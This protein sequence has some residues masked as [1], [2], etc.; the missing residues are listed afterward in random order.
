MLELAEKRWRTSTDC[1]SAVNEPVD[2]NV[3]GCRHSG[4]ARR[5][6][7]L[8]GNVRGHRLTSSRASGRNTIAAFAL[9]IALGGARCGGIRRRN[10]NGNHNSHLKN[11]VTNARSSLCHIAMKTRIKNAKRCNTDFTI[12]SKPGPY[13]RFRMRIPFFVMSVLSYTSCRWR[14]PEITRRWAFDKVHDS[15]GATGTK[16]TLM[17]P[18]LRQARAAVLPDLS[19]CDAH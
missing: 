18:G 13:L 3:C 5:T 11:G 4:A 1:Y 19:A 15:A 12:R 9:S 6:G 7:M 16:Q 8:P 17:S 10:K 14:I 2:P